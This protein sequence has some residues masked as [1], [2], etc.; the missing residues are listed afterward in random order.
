MVDIDDC[1]PA[2]EPEPEPISSH[3]DPNSISPDAWRRFESAADA[4]VRKIQ[5]TVSSER[6]RAAVIDYVQRLFRFSVGCQVFPFGS[7]PLKTYLPDGDIDLTAFGPASSDENL[8]N[9]IRGILESEEKRKDAEFEVKDVQ[10]I[11]AEVKLVKCLVQ[12]IVVDIS[13]NQIGGLCTLS[14]LEKVDQIF[15]KNH[16]FKRSIILIKD[17][18]YYESRILGAHHGLISTYALETLVL[19]IFHLFQKSLDGPLAVLYR[20][21]DYY[22]K[23]DWDNKGISLF[24]PVSLSSLPELVTDPPDTRDD[25]FLP[26]EELLKEFAEMFSVPPRNSE[27][28]ARVFS[29]KFLNI[30]DPLKQS[31]NLGRSVSKGNFYRI[32]SAFDFGA[33]ELGKILQVPAT[34]TVNEVNQ[35]FRNTLKRNRTGLRPDVLVSSSDGLITDHVTSDS[36]SLDFNVERVNMGCSPL[37]YSNHCG[38]LSNQFNNI[39]ISC[40]NIHGTIKQKERNS[41]A[42]QK[43]IK[44]VS[45]GLPDSDSTNHTTTNS[46]SMRNDGDLCEASPTTIETCT[47]PSG[48]G[49]RAPHFFYQSENGK[50]V[51]LKDDTNPSHCGVSTKRFAGRSPHSFEVAKH[52]NDFP[53]GVTANDI[54]SDL[55]GD[56]STNYNNLLYAQQCQHENPTNQVYYQMLRSPPAQYQNTRSSNGHGR[57]NAYG[58]A[59]TNGV[60]PGPP[61]SPG[62]FVFR[63]F[64]Q[65]DDPTAMRARGRGTGTYFPD[66]N[67]RKDR[68]SS[69]RGE[70]GR[71]HFPPNSYQ[72]F[73]NHVRRDMP[74]DTRPLDE[75]TQELPLQIYVPGAYDHGIPSPLMIPVPSPSPQ[76]PRDTLKVPTHSPSSQVARDIFHG[77]GFMHPQ[78]SKLGFGTL[79]I[80][81]LEATS[82]DHAS[83]SDSS[84]NNQASGPVSPLSA[85]KNPEVGSN[86]LRNGQTYHLKDNGDFPPLSS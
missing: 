25:G 54:V 44:F 74:A 77:N 23:F 84:S 5:P 66:P 86:R 4:V 9:E 35:F 20:F 17:W 47:L 73:H 19:Y 6:L 78:D 55:T 68:P 64:Y 22:S 61:Y 27:T 14:F 10:Y 71:N 29:R 12:N 67:L 65:T 30:V 62:Y 26:R 21:L 59:G 2:P 83:R 28:N 37:S 1:S 8:A 50:K 3:P 40:S 57:S 31:N 76:S 56:F 46:V 69:G 49:N 79:G 85:A 51:D 34:S 42:A 13:F 82:K 41:M 18:C 36:M 80:L 63:P 58:Y 32:R 16:L 39:S 52:H 45:G 24:G 60:V 75:L 11:N 38:D 70:R 81:P 7:V 72:K 53:P 43:E 48:R 15:G 33:R